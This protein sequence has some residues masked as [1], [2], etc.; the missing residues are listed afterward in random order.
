MAELSTL[1]RPYAK[2]AFSAAV[3]AGS[4]PEW[5]TAL[6]TLAQ[7]TKA[8]KVS[9]LLGSPSVSALEKAKAVTTIAGDECNEGAKNLLVVLA[10]NNRF[11][12]LPEISTQFELLKAEHDK[13]AEVVV[14]SAF[15]LSDAQQKVLTEKL[16]AKLE[17]EVSLTVDIDETLIGG[18]IIR[19]GDLVIDDSVRGKLSKLADAMNS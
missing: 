6:Q 2:A 14:T 4:I 17:R 9:E 19:A 7:V 16:T 11:A 3:D 15:K 8:D 1:A 5:S 12:L 13:S 10:E 18:V